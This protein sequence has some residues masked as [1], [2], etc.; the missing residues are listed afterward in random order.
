M[1]KLQND[2]ITNFKN[3]ANEKIIDGS[4][5]LHYANDRL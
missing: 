4:G 5:S 3:N 2:K 1:T